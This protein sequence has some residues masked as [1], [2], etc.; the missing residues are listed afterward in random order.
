MIYYLFKMKDN[1]SFIILNI[2]NI[3]IIIEKNNFVFIINIYEYIN[4]SNC[5]I[6]KTLLML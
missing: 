2:I 1:I 5:N 6:N 3:V 4:N